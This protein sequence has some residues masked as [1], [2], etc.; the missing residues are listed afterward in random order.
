MVGEPPMQYLALWRM[1]LASRRFADGARVSEA[2]A[3]AGYES[4]AAFTRAFKKAMGRS[5]VE[6][7][8]GELR[9]GS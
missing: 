2:E 8:R 4:E 7:R 5:P 1:Q 6:W 9:P 3:A